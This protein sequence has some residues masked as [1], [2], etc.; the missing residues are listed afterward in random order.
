[1]YN[2]DM[3]K[4][5]QQLLGLL[6]GDSLHQLLIMPRQSSQPILPTTDKKPFVRQ[7]MTCRFTYIM[8]A[9]GFGGLQFT[10][11]SQTAMY[12]LLKFAERS[13]CKLLS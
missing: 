4:C 8:F 12:C 7:K 3:T 5:S 10:R 9:I 2:S 11:V 6:K 1:M 13:A